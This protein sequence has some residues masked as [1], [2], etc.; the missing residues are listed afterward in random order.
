MRWFREVCKVPEKKFRICLHIHTLHC[1]KDVK[2]YW[3][4][5]TRIPTSQFYKTQTKPTSLRQR[6]NKLYN[7][8]CAISV[9]NKALFRKIKGWK[10]GFIEKIDII[11]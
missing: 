3:S 7:G 11:K 1:R 6:K 9:G 4:N 8:T 5:I 2:E 10:I